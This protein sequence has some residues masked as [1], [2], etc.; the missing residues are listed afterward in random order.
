MNRNLESLE[1]FSNMILFLNCVNKIELKLC[2]EFLSIKIEILSIL[3]CFNLKIAFLA[4]ELKNNTKIYESSVK[5]F[6]FL[7]KLFWN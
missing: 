3:K 1:M 4:F 6:F 7:L 2:F 5:P